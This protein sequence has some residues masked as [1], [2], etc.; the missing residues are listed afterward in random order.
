MN[1]Q[2]Q[3]KIIKRGAVKIISEQ[4]LIRK[5]KLSQKENR[6]LRIKAGFDPTAADIHLGHTVLLRKL[7]QFQDLG[8]EVQFLIGD[9]TARI[10][11]P[12]G[13]SQLRKPLKQEEI[14]QNARTYTQ[15]ISKILK[16]EEL[17]T[18]FNSE[19]FDAMSVAEILKLTMHATVSQMLARADF[20]SAWKTMRRFHY[21]NS[22]IQS[23]RAMTQS[24]LRAILSWGAQ[25]RFLIF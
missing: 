6:P 9:F 17:K 4:E 14:V 15:Q 23:C 7:R 20:K 21:L 2:E 1:I 19:W 22:C 13:R 18:V 5:L 10:G 25:I 24:C 8:H 3:L 16:L 11:D 12:S